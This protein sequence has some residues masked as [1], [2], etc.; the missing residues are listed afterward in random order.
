MDEKYEQGLF[1]KFTRTD[2][3]MAE[4][5]PLLKRIESGDIV[6]RPA[7]SDDKDNLHELVEIARKRYDDDNEILFFAYPADGTRASTTSGKLVLNYRH[8]TIKNPDGTIKKMSTSLQSQKKDHLRSVAINTNRDIVIQL[9]DKD[10]SPI[11]A[12]TWHVMTFQQFQEI[13]IT[14]TETTNVF[15]FACTNPKHAYEMAGETTIAIGREERNQIKTDKDTHFTGAIVQ[16]ANEKENVTGL[17]ANEITI[18][19]IAVQSDQALYY[20]LWIYES[21]G[22]EDTDFDL[23]QFVDYVDIDLA[24]NGKQLGAA[25]QYYYAVTGLE[26]AYED[27]DE[28]NELHYALENLS[29]AAKNAGATGE[30]VIKTLYTPRT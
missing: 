7:K 9:D 25:N 23:D 12:D 4:M 5:M 28:S 8:G 17:V 19:S 1:D 29:A 11:R 14:T 2:E 22:F 18:T 27:L 16:N 3:M 30:I 13:T 24:T 21:D 10:K 15:I 26:I 6:V 20:R